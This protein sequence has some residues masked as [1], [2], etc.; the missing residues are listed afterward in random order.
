MKPDRFAP[1]EQLHSGHTE[2]HTIDSWGQPEVLDDSKRLH[3]NSHVTVMAVVPLDSA[4]SL[5][6]RRLLLDMENS[7]EL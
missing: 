6:D 7:A 3:T 1:L 2:I 4:L 5:R